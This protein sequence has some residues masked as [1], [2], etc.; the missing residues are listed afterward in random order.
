MKK[1]GVDFDDTIIKTYGP[2]INYISSHFSMTEIDNPVGYY[3]SDTFEIDG[4]DMT[5][6]KKLIGRY[7]NGNKKLPEIMNG[8]ESALEKM[9]QQNKDLEFWIISSRTIYTRKFIEETIANSKIL[10]KIFHNNR[11]IVQTENVV[12][13]RFPTEKFSKG[14]LCKKYGIEIFIDDNYENIIDIIDNGIS[15]I[16]FGN[17]SNMLDAPKV[18]PWD[19]VMGLDVLKN[20]CKEN[21]S[22]LGEVGSWNDIPDIIKKYFF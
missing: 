5:D 22:F 18:Y 21:K 14:K 6:I 1:I 4:M 16:K 7:F 2:F 19:R 8:C 17:S 13:D 9:T 10:S 12:L 11:I 15:T 20:K 3:Y